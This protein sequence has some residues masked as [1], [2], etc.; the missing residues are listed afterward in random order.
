ML[1][2]E[3]L[4]KHCISHQLHIVQDGAEALSFL[5][6]M[7]QAGN[8]LCP[9]L[10][11]LDLNLPN[12]EGPQILQ[13]IRKHP[14]CARTPVII[15]TSSDAKEDRARVA[16]LGIAYYFQK[17]LDFDDFLQLGAIVQAMI[18]DDA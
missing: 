16:D 14:N 7:G 2:Q 1:V 13:E 17:P 18:K 6:Q 12:I 15:V 3:A 5:A 8:F 11:L 9:D 4:E 10:V